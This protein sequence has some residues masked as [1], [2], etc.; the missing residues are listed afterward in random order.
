M[1]AADVALMVVRAW[2]AVVMLA[3][4]IRHAKT[5]EGTAGWFSSLGWDHAH[6]QARFS[7]LGEIAMAVGIGAGLLT[8][9]AAAGVIA[10][11]TVAFWT[12]HRKA[13]FFVF[14]RPDEGYEYVG[15][16]AATMF[17]LAVI[18]PGQVSLDHVLELGLDGWLGAAI[19]VSGI[20]VAIGHLVLF[21][22]EP[23]GD[24]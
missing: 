1:E 17:A 8:S 3:H 20:I 6:A 7:A 21:W 12:V 4:G 5:I 16:L 14:A 19:A 11:M 23:G 9:V 10:T 24:E 15:T 13:G 18:G 22:E 2:V